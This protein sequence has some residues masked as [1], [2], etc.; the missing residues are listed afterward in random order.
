MGRPKRTAKYKQSKS[1]EAA[2]Q[3]ESEID[4]SL[5]LNHLNQ[6]REI[7]D[8]L[9]W[10]YDYMAR[11]DY[12]RQQIAA[13]KAAPDW[14]IGT[15]A[16]ALAHLI[17][18]GCNV[19]ARAG[20]RVKRVIETCI[21]L[22]PVETPVIKP[23]TTT[24][25]KS[26]VKAETAMEDLEQALDEFVQNGFQSTFKP[27]DLFKRYDVKAKYAQKIIQYYSRLQEELI[28]AVAGNN[29]EV[30]EGYSHITKANLK[31]YLSFV[32]LIINDAQSIASVKKAVRRTRK[33]KE[34]SLQQ[35]TQK[36]SYL[37]ESPLYKVASV[38]PQKIIKA[39]TVI[40][41]N[42][43]YR[44]LTVL[45]AQSEAGLSISRTT[46]VNIDEQQS[47]SKRLRKPEQSLKEILSNGK[48]YVQ[49]YVKGI[50][51]QPGPVTGRMNEDTII[52]RVF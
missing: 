27:F 39:Q 23:A 5:A 43:K 6:E 14:K 2:Y 12:T 37:K 38:D 11:N 8:M 19:P 10:I 17:N 36:L 34:K 52:L 35:L 31:R 24:Y 15:T 33:P 21:N 47:F 44:K 28:I 45:Q 26:S 18:L 13:V 41:F 1:A 32:S 4:L 42:T 46:I 16:C 51:A 49:K 29:P 20:E 25:V 50:N 48:I 9:P 7:K 40:L 30:N 3:I 22:K